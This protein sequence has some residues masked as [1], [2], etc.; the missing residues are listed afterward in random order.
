MRGSLRKQQA[1]AAAINGEIILQAAGVF[2]VLTCL[3]LHKF[4][5]IPNLGYTAFGHRHGCSWSYSK[6][7][8]NANGHGNATNTT[9][10]ATTS[11]LSRSFMFPLFL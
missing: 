9:K 4:K 3:F 10:N 2:Q 6:P 1:E 5:L 11:P 8:S 7:R